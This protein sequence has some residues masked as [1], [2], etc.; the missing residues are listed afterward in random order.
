M[1]RLQSSSDLGARLLGLPPG[2]SPL[3]GLLIGQAAFAIIFLALAKLVASLSTRAS[4]AE[5]ESLPPV[6][7]TVVAWV[8]A[9]LALPVLLFGAADRAMGDTGSECWLW[10][11]MGDRVTIPENHATEPPREGYFLRRPYCAHSSHAQ[12]AAGCFIFA[13]VQMGDRS[14]N[15]TVRSA[16]ASLLLAAALLAAGLASYAWWGARR[17]RA[18]RADHVMMDTQCWA[19]VGLFLS[20]AHPSVRTNTASTSTQSM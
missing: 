16:W 11:L 8:L 9:G 14:T 3:L 6:N 12:I 17:R 19:L 10:R 2:D 15:G 7:A 4:G 5:A 18:L 13:Q 1:K 20:A